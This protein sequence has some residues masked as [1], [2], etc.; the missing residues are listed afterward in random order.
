MVR[1]YIKK[2]PVVEAVRWT[3]YNFDEIQHFV[4]VK[5]AKFMRETNPPEIYIITEYQALHPGIGDYIVKNSYS[6]FDIYT[7]SCFEQSF[8]EATE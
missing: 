1:R 6:S 4:G 2:P 7:K 5:N 3:G 8:E